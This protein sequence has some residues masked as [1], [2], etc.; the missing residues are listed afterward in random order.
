MRIFE[1]FSISF[2][3]GN[4][5]IVNDSRHKVFVYVRDNSNEDIPRKI[6]VV[7]SRRYTLIN[8]FPFTLDEL[9]FSVSQSSID[10]QI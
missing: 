6:L 3:D 8:D 1:G 10:E 2:K 4:A 7:E 9:M 5:K